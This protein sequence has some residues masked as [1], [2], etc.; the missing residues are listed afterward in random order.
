MGT[1]PRVVRVLKVPR[2]LEVLRVRVLKV[3]RVR[4]LKVPMVRG[5]WHLQHPHHQHHQRVSHLPHLQP[6]YRP[7]TGPITNRYRCGLSDGIRYG[8]SGYAF[9]LQL[10]M[11]PAPIWAPSRLRKICGRRGSW[12]V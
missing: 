7:S 6:V 3:L 11:P 10:S 9:R 4:V 1:G 5:C 8:S 12:K 2:V